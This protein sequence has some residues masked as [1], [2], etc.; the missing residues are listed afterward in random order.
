[1]P[2]RTTADL[3]KDQTDQYSER[4]KQAWRRVFNRVHQATG[5][6]EQAFKAAH[7]AAKRVSG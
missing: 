2:Y 6:D 5:S 7:A 4:A 3:P 1:M